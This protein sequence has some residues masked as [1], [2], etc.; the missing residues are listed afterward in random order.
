MRNSLCGG[1]GSFSYYKPE[2]LKEIAMKKLLSILTAVVLCVAILGM[3]GCKEP[4]KGK[5]NVKYYATPNDIV[6]L[7]LA[8]NETIGLIPEPAATALISLFISPIIIGTA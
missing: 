4:E 1:E 6:P 8:G 7:I 3:F 5:A 2:R